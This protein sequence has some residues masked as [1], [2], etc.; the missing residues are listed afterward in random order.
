MWTW[1]LIFTQVSFCVLGL[2]KTPRLGS[3]LV[4]VRLWR[5]HTWGAVTP[6]HFPLR[7]GLFWL[8]HWRPPSLCHLAVHITLC[9]YTRSP[10]AGKPEPNSR[11]AFI[12]P[13]AASNTQA[14]PVTERAL[15]WKC[16]LSFQHVKAK[17]INDV[18]PKPPNLMRWTKAISNFP[19]KS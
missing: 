2:Y 1:T 13:A 3:V 12:I 15:C 5:W 7:W 18:E 16:D 8:G 10:C 9:V 4:C 14:I 19:L 6:A 11:P 17:I